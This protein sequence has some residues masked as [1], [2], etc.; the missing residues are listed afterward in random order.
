MKHKIFKIIIFC[1]E[2]MIYLFIYSSFFGSKSVSKIYFGDFNSGKKCAL[3]IIIALFALILKNLVYFFSYDLMN[4]KIMEL[5]LYFINKLRI[6]NNHKNQKEEND[7]E[8]NNIKD[9][10]INYLKIQF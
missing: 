1:W 4:K 7:V 5:K 2:L 10:T 9:K 6:N 8:F 3:G